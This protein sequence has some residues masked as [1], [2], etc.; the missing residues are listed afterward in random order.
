MFG[1]SAPAASAATSGTC[2]IDVDAAT[3]FSTTQS[4]GFGAT[5]RMGCASNAP[6]DLAALTTSGNDVVV[7]VDITGGDASAKI[8]EAVDAFHTAHDGGQIL[9]RYADAQAS[10]YDLHL[11]DGDTSVS[12]VTFDGNV[13]A[14]GNSMVFVVP[15]AQVSTTANWWQ[16]L[17]GTA[18]S[19]GIGVVAGAACLTILSTGGPFVAP[20]CAA[21]MG[22]AIG[23]SG[24]M[25]QNVGFDG[26][27]I[28]SSSVLAEAFAVGLMSA[29]VGGAGGTVLEWATKGSLALTTTMQTSLKNLAAKLNIFSKP[30]NAIA[31]A[32]AGFDPALIQAIRQ[33][34]GGAIGQQIAVASYIYPTDSAWTRLINSPTGKTSV[35]VANVL[36]GPGAE[37][38]SAWGDVIDKAAASGKKVLGYVDTGYF[39]LADGRAT[40]LGST[41][42]ADWTQQIEEDI[43]SW[44]SLYGSSMG[45]IFFD[46]GYNEC[47]SGNQVPSWYTEVNDYVKRSH[48]GALT[49]L[50][51]GT[52]VPQCYE[53]TADV[54]L[55]YEG[56]Y[57]GYVGTNSN[58]ALN[59]KD[60]G[61]TPKSSSEIW[62]I[63]YG[64]SADHVAEVAAKAKD[65]GAGYVEITDDTL[66]N[67]YDTL[68]ADSYWNAEQN[69]VEG[70][71]PTVAGAS[72]YA[73]TTNTPV[74]PANLTVKSYDYTSATLTWGASAGAARYKISVNGVITTVPGSMTSATVGGLTPGGSS[75][76]IRVIAQ[77]GGGTDSAPSNTAVVKTL[78]LPG[79]K[80][81][82]NVRVSATATTATIS[83]DFLVPYSFRR[84]YFWTPTLGITGC[85]G[86][87]AWTINYRTDSYVC[88]YYMV[89]GTTLYRYTG[90]ANSQWSWAPYGTVTISRSGYTYTWNVPY[91]TSG[92]VSADHV[93]LQAEGYNPLVNYFT[94]CSEFSPTLGPDGNGRYCAS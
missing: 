25:I 76:E 71:T 38:N 18:A 48:P 69:A 32:L 2:G 35:V 46:D 64:V 10:K 59:Y 9:S 16:K 75:Y 55:T 89:E 20:V 61:W 72:A 78:A 50:N 84:L 6:S 47:G 67:P 87:A 73:G 43:N 24:E 93:V 70:G 62:H 53:G 42:P 37:K 30:L 52:I 44:Y 40:R 54:L 14:K 15:A 66:S 45:G 41:S 17:I 7:S 11:Y 65:R 29:V 81:V 21:V 83:A 94:P 68:P 12:G 57:T 92:G 77:T 1:L 85:Q 63:I 80:T 31:D 22:F 3:G 51:P 4:D 34:V 86:G 33:R 56:D 13:Y 82:T 91:G 79:G 28:G 19:W 60:L 74:A 26:R 23:F 36:N 58:A 5:F 90:T 88:G 27:P 8:K 39:G 49:V